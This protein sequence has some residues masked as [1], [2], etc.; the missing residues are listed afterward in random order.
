MICHRVRGCVAAYRPNA[1]ATTARMTSVTTL[2]FVRLL[3]SA[4]AAA[5]KRRDCRAMRCESRNPSILQ[6]RGDVAKPLVVRL[7]R[8]VNSAFALRLVGIRS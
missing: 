4:G 8:H 1:T 5:I 6:R 3:R 7:L 2:S